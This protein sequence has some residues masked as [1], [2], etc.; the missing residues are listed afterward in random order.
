[1]PKVAQYD[2]N[3]VRTEVVRQPLAQDAPTA[4]FGGSIAKG[5]ADLAQSGIKIKQRVDTTSAEEALVAFERDK[6]D[7]FFNP[8][9]GYFNTQ[10][11]NA[12]DNSTIATQSLED[13]KKQHSKT[14]GEQARIMFEKS[15]DAH[16]T[17]G[18][19]DIAR[20][21]SKGLKAWEISTLES[22]VENSIENASLYY[23]DPDQLRVQTALGRQAIIDSSELAGIG[24]EATAE[25]L[26]TFD[27]SF[28]KTSIEA[29]LSSS[30]A[31]GE[32]ALETYSDRLEGPD[33][34]KL[35]KQLDKIKEAEKTQANANAA[36]LASTALVDQY[37]SRS[38][39]REAV[40]EIEDPELRKVTMTEAM[41]QFSRK[42]QAEKE[43]EN[44]FYQN[45]ISLV[46]EGAT[47][48]EIA[49]QDAD[50]WLGMTDI[51]R[52]NILSGKHMI[53]DQAL[54]QSLRSLPASEKAKLNAVDYSAKLKPTDLNKLTTEIEAA[55]K[56][57]QGSR[58]R[59][60]AS[61]SMGAAEAAFGKKTKWTTKR[62]KPTERGILANQF[63]SDLQEVID[64]AELEKQGRITPAEEDKIIG[65]F[66][67]QIA[68]ER[69]RFGFD[70]LA[71]D[72]EIDLSNTPPNDLR[73]LN[74]IVDG[75]PNIDLDDLASSYRL[76]VDS[77]I[78][79]TPDNL[80]EVYRQGRQ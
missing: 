47:P 42:E 43:K 66:T 64:E 28:A 46:N 54:F 7:I 8:D 14:L 10:G 27:S 26:Q 78:P 52:N 29:A 22:Q 53:T 21:A 9:T 68:I 73:M 1:M 50:A 55:K 24:P 48:S 11:R 62:G 5:V 45:A 75:T 58:I 80:R 31:E 79:I 3:R 71:A 44:A 18:Q 74:R 59:S 61:K 36:V 49:A 15:A 60:L 40:N 6:N 25:K 76:L 35:E 70:I 72:I 41:S 13:L 32:K 67:R 17:R 57:K 34:I 38:D 77:E 39:V 69:S 33:K 56:G 30:A 19:S 51:Q 2:G 12:Y 16:I 37:D 4:A 23:D 20:H 65:E 63:I